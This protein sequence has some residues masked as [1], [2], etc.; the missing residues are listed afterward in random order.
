[1]ASEMPSARLATHK[2]LNSSMRSNTTKNMLLS[3]F[4]FLRAI[5]RFT[6]LQ[7]ALQSRR[8][9]NAIG[10]HSADLNRGCVCGYLATPVS[11]AIIRP[12][13]R[14]HRLINQVN[15]GK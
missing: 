7:N 5:D 14:K 8:A 2:P 6:F 3:L 11:R 13:C 4:P 10:R 15:E 12:E 1:M 9:A